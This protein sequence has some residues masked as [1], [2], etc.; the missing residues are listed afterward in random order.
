MLPMSALAV[1]FGESSHFGSPARF[2]DQVSAPQQFA[3]RSPREVLPRKQSTLPDAIKRLVKSTAKAEGVDPALAHAVIRAESN[4]NPNA[5]SRA[6]A[7]GLMQLMPVTAQ[8]FGVTNSFDAAQN[9]VGGIKYLGWLGRFFNRNVPLMLA[10]YNAGENAVIKHGGI[11]PYTET[12]NY[13]AAVLND[14]AL[15]DLK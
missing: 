4:G 5:I 1:P 14:Y 9:V 6:G 12:Q 11:P 7:V 10:G 8:R 2:S 15:G 13:V 3:V